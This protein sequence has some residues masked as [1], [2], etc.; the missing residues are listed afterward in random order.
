[1]ENKDDLWWSP[2]VEEKVWGVG[3]ELAKNVGRVETM[4][5][6][7]NCCK[8]FCFFL[9]ILLIGLGCG[10]I[11]IKKTSQALVKFQ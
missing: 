1:M 10:G 11:T 8:S 3:E 5:V 4:S 2:V 6:S 7:E 9:P